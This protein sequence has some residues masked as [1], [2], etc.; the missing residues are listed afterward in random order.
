MEMVPKADG[1]LDVALRG[2]HNPTKNFAALRPRDAKTKG[3]QPADPDDFTRI[4]SPNEPFQ[5]SF[6]DL[7][8]NLHLVSN[9]DPVKDQVVIVYAGVSL[10]VMAATRIRGAVRSSL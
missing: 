1:S 3:L 10:N 9:T 2:F 5:F 8:G 7:A 4:R 6:P